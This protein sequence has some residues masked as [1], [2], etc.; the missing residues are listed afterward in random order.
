MPNTASDVG[1]DGHLPPSAFEETPTYRFAFSWDGPYGR[2][3]HLVEEHAPA[4]LVLDL[5]CG[6]GAVGEVLVERGRQYVGADVDSLAIADLRKRSLEGHVLD[7]TVREGLGE[8][9]AALTA[10]HPEVRC[11]TAAID[12]HLDANGYIIPGLGDA[13]DRIFGTR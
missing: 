9:I 13:G 6:Y 4:G 3:V 2:A 12:S 10:A 11:W 7:L 1:A 8:G 5:G